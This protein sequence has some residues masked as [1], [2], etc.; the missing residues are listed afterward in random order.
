MGRGSGHR[1]ADFVE[2]KAGALKPKHCETDVADSVSEERGGG[3]GGA[4]GGPR[5]FPLAGRNRGPPSI[6]CSGRGIGLAPLSL[7]AGRCIF[8]RGGQQEKCIFP[9]ATFQRKVDAAGIFYGR[10]GSIYLEGFLGWS[11]YNVTMGRLYTTGPSIFFTRGTPT[12]FY[13]QRAASVDCNTY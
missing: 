7:K 13:V 2:S 4:Q 8:S 5:K 10:G 12:P 9:P 3:G 1:T 6:L 11:P